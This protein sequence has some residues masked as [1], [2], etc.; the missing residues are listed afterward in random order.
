MRT[1]FPKF[2]DTSL[3]ESIYLALKF[4]YSQGFIDAME[5]ENHFEKVIDNWFGVKDEN[6]DE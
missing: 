6:D 3:D 5:S 4:A 2:I 1:M